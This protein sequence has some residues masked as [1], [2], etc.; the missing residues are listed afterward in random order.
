VLSGIELVA[1]RIPRGVDSR[2]IEGVEARVL[3][4]APIRLPIAMRIYTQTSLEEAARSLTATR[5]DFLHGPRLVHAGVRA[6]TS[7]HT[8]E[9]SR[10]ALR[11]EGQAEKHDDRHYWCQESRLDFIK[12]ES[13]LPFIKGRK[14]RNES[15]PE[16]G[17][18]AEVFK[19]G[20]ILVHLSTCSCHAGSAHGS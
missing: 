17:A 13:S 10:D 4:P 2:S 7:C 16:T 18:F 14:E 11:D 20:I 5:D 15:L 19:H 12:G 9:L 1:D 6:Q 3:P 8:R